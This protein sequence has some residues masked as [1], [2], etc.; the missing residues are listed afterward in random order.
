MRWVTIPVL[1]L[2]MAQA[3]WAGDP[4]TALKSAGTLDA[5]IEYRMWLLNYCAKIDP[6]EAAK[7][8]QILKDFEQQTRGYREKIEAI[9]RLE[10]RKGSPVADAAAVNA[11]TTAAVKKMHDDQ[12]RMNMKLS[13]YD[14]KG[15][16]QKCDYVANPESRAKYGAS[17]EWKNMLI[18]P[19][20][21]AMPD[22]AA[23]LRDWRP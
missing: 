9:A 14:A 8:G 19:I 3:S 5:F 17:N 23:V 6:G 13:E 15:S 20:E 11:A 22:E 2:V 10:V 12:D 4:P 1:V 16:L 21:D 7:F 18:N